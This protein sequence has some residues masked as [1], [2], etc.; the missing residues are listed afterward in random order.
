[1]KNLVC[2]TT[3]HHKRC[4][5]RREQ[6]K[7]LLARSPVIILFSLGLSLSLACF[8]WS[9]CVSHSW[10]R[11]K[12]QRSNIVK[13]MVSVSWAQFLFCCTFFIYWLHRLL[14]K[15]LF[16]VYM[17]SHNLKVEKK[18]ERV[19]A[20]N[21]FTVVVESVQADNFYRPLATQ[22]VNRMRN[23]RSQKSSMGIL[24][25]KGGTRIILVISYK[26]T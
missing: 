3:H 15:N 13:Q 5:Q 8:L 17:F 18:R 14:D 4:V 12:K 10:G 9:T 7:C 6:N 19:I 22:Q 25:Q 2:I 23:E 16:A 26:S 11:T 21:L 1:M 24:R 20:W